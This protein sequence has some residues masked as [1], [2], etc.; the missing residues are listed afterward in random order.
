MSED[1]KEYR[2]EYDPGDFTPDGRLINWTPKQAAN[3]LYVQKFK[4]YA[5]NCL[6]RQMC[7]DYMIPCTVVSCPF[8]NYTRQMG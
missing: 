1:Q 5:V 7:A 2:P 4:E 8:E 3:D 6:L